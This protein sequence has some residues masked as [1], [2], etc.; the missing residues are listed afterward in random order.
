MRDGCP[1]DGTLP[2]H[3][4]G[5]LRAIPNWDSLDVTSPHTMSPRLL[6]L[7]LFLSFLYLCIFIF[8]PLFPTTTKKKSVKKN[9]IKIMITRPHSWVAFI[10]I[11]DSSY[12]YGMP[13]F[14]VSPNPARTS[15]HYL[16]N[17]PNCFA[18]GGKDRASTADNR[19]SFSSVCTEYQW[20]RFQIPTT[21][22]CPLSSICY[23]IS[24]L[25]RVPPSITHWTISV[26][27]IRI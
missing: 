20:W 12:G 18:P 8:P 14:P 24:D 3:T 2:I 25:Y 17:F 7:F 23:E 11:Y 22:V 27:F 16:G 13:T 21:Q 4:S 9:E 26:G 15:P 10:S 5:G 6:C 19:W 1:S